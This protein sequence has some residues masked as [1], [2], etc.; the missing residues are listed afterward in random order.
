MFLLP[1]TLISIYLSNLSSFI[2]FSLSLF[3]IL[4]LP[5]MLLPLSS[6]PAST[7]RPRLFHF[8]LELVTRITGDGNALPRC[9]L[10]LPNSLWRSKPDAS[11]LLAMLSWITHEGDSYNFFSLERS[12]EG[13]SPHRFNHGK[14]T[15]LDQKVPHWCSAG[16]TRTNA[17]DPGFAGSR[18]KLKPFVKSCCFAKMLFWKGNLVWE[19]WGKLNNVR[20]ALSTFSLYHIFIRVF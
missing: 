3:R 20:L 10:V 19:N 8:G 9:A 1:S 16:L 11:E 15:S 5:F 4:F 6:H 2:F 17:R 13:V 14:P 12:Q 18:I 7:C